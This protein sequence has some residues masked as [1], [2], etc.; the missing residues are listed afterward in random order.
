MQEAK[1]RPVC[2]VDTER[3]KVLESI[4][5]WQVVREAAGGIGVLGPVVMM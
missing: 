1:Q 2:L 5:G 3:N 4:T